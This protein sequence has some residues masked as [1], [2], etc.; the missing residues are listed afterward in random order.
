MAAE[1][2]TGEIIMTVLYAL[3]MLI[4]LLGNFILI[5]I[6]W[7]VREARSLTSF[8]FFNMAVADLLVTVSVMPSNINDFYNDF[9]WPIKG[10]FGDFTCRTVQ[11]INHISLMASI[12]S[13]TFMAI[14]RFYVVNY[15]LESRARTH[16]FRDSKYVSPLIW[17]LS[18][19]LMPIVPILYFLNKQNSSCELYPL[20]N[21]KVTILAF[22]VF[23]FLAT[24]LCP[25]VIITILYGKT[26]R[27]IWF[28]RTPGER[29]SKTQQSQDEISKKRVIRMLVFIVTVFALCWLPVHIK[30]F[31]FAARI[32]GSSIPNLPQ[33]VDL[34]TSW[35]AHA[36]SAINPWLYIG[37][38]TKIRLAFLHLLGRRPREMAIPL[39]R[40]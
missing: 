37:L 24:Y 7:K 17:I 10:G 4:S 11:Y 34:L 31:L 29:L 5:Y 9:N 27:T 35:L 20:G 15:P 22:M 39:E 30:N 3:T 18:S 28:R 40:I 38:S 36:N 1:G 33:I 23:L 32:S 26:A 19:A 25:L 14:D 6:I 13:L 12:L 8:M 2:K 16:W 21:Y